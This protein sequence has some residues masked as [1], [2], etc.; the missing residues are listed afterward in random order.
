MKPLDPRAQDALHAR[1]RQLSKSSTTVKSL[2]VGDLALVEYK[3]GVVL[4][5][6]RDSKIVSIRFTD[7][8]A[9]AV[10]GILNEIYSED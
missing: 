7:E 9:G 1:V 2:I 6:A 5:A 8:Q 4:L 3:K 10:A